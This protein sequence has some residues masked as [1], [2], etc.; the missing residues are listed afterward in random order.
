MTDSISLLIFS[1][2]SGLL[3]KSAVNTCIVVEVVT[4]PVGCD[5]LRIKDE[6]DFFIKT[7]CGCL[8]PK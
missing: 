6:N 4:V 7:C 8:C 1:W 3:T 2:S 5:K